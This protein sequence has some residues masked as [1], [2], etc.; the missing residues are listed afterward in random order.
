MENII[1]IETQ[2]LEHVGQATKSWRCGEWEI[3]EAVEGDGRGG[4]GDSIDVRG[5]GRR[6][7]RASCEEN[8]NGEFAVIAAKNELTKLYHGHQV[9]NAWSGVKDYCILHFW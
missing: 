7:K 8:D 2:K 1:I 4:L 3:R 6:V 5:G 9:A